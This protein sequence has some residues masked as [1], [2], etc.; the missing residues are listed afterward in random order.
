M[1]KNLFIIVTVILMGVAVHAGDS[2]WLSFDAGLEK[3]KEEKK[4]VL[5]DFYT[6][7]CHWCKVM[8]EKTF[9]EKNVKAKLEKHFVT[10][11][12][13]AEDQSEQATYKGNT[14]NNVQLSRAFGVTGYPTIGFL[15]HD[16]DL[17]DTISGYIPAETFIHI[18]T[19]IEEKMYDQKMPFQE[20]LKLQEEKSKE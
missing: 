15:E 18:L 5:V 11:R 9:N 4:P 2:S 17:I 1:M 13:N 10:V 20:F 12:I 16:G 14:Y 19:Y 8:D 6:D 7:W 3:A